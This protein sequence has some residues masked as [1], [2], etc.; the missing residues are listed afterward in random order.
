MAY[1]IISV[2]DTK[3]ACRATVDL[4]IIPFSA[5]MK[6]EVTANKICFSMP[7]MCYTMIMATN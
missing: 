5:H 2:N 3:A 4:I 1:H 7:V 6:F